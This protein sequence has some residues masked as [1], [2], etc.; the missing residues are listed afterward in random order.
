[1]RDSAWKL[2]LHLAD[3]HKISTQKVTSYMSL[4]NCIRTNRNCPWRGDAWDDIPSRRIL[5]RFF[6]ETLSSKK[7]GYFTPEALLISEDKILTKDEKKKQLTDDH[8]LSGQ[9]YGTFVVDTFDVKGD[10]DLGL[11][12]L[13]HHA[14]IASQTIRCTVDENIKFRKFTENDEFTG[15]KLQLKVPTQE[16]YAASGIAQLWDSINGRYVKG[17]PIDLCDEFLEFQKQHLL[18]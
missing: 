12:F 2:I 8:V 6:Y 15:G 9:A 16:R 5:T 17:F 4:Y 14:L 13:I 10:Q 18:I 3:K 11:D 1:M 7:T